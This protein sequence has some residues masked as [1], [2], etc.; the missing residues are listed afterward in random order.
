[1]DK[2]GKGLEF[3][4][5]HNSEEGELDENAKQIKDQLNKS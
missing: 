3:E 2:E 4:K 5:F 1:M